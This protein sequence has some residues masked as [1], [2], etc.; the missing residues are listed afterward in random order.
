MEE[1]IFYKEFSKDALD[2]IR[3]ETKQN[4]IKYNFGLIDNE[5]MYQEEIGKMIHM[6]KY[7]VS[8]LEQ[9]AFKTIKKHSK[10]LSYKPNE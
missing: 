9:I 10:T 6:R 8:S 3:N 5:P 2:V 1:S 7:L 4:L